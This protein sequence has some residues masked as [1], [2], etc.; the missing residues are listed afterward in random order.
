MSRNVSHTLLLLLSFWIGGRK[1]RRSCFFHCDWYC[2]VACNGCDRTW[3]MQNTPQNIIGQNILV[4]KLLYWPNGRICNFSDSATNIPCFPWDFSIIIKIATFCT[5]EKVY[6][7]YI[8]YIIHVIR[9]S[10]NLR[11]LL[12]GK[13]RCLILSHV[14]ITFQVAK[15]DGLQNHMYV[16]FTKYICSRPS[17]KYGNFSVTTLHTRVL[18][19][20]L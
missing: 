17:C 6:S 11:H 8:R 20:L 18:V 12:S 15:D 14:D 4:A 9:Y 5:C 16:Y 3:K 1:I 19:W 13:V 2:G 10:N 7:I